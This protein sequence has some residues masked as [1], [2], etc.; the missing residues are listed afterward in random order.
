MRRSKEIIIKIRRKFID[1]FYGKVITFVLGL[2]R[3]G[4]NVIS[5]KADSGINIDYLY[6]GKPKGLFSVGQ[7]IDRVLLHLPAVKATKTKKDIIIKIIHN[8]VANNVILEDTTRILDLA[9]GPARYLV[10][11]VNQFHYGIDDVEVLCIDN[12]QKSV[13]FG[14]RIGKNMP[15]RF[16]KANI[17]KLGTL[18]RFSRKIGWKPSLILCTGFFELMND[19][20]VK[21]LLEEIY[22]FI[23]VEG[24]LLFTSQAN[25]PSKKLMKRIGKRQNG[26]PWRMYFRDTNKLRKWLLD[27][28]FR[29]VIVSLDSWGMYEYCTGRKIERRIP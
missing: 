22:D 12:D 27:I 11:F 4:K 5:G 26:L 2:S 7:F 20:Y 24:L 19:E 14:K 9:S 15:I 6:C 23:S 21:E 1:L 18:K 16:V 28:G 3:I 25:N 29:D 13:N 10:D 8:E 17:F